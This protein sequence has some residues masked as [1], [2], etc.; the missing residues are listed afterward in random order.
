MILRRTLTRC[1]KDSDVSRYQPCPW[2]QMA[3][4]RMVSNSTRV[5]LAPIPSTHVFMYHKQKVSNPLPGGI[6]SRSGIHSDSNWSPIRSTAQNHA[7]SQR[8][9]CHKSQVN[10]YTQTTRHFLASNKRFSKYLTGSRKL[11]WIL[12]G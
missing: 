4:R 1:L 5:N 3:F 9:R 6:M 8:L 7:S 10:K 12:D 2:H 11:I